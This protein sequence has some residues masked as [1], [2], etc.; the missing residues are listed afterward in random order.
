MHI[1][2]HSLASFVHLISLNETTLKWIVFLEFIVS[3]GLIIA[4]DG[5]DSEVLWTSIEYDSSFLGNRR[6]HEYCSEVNCIVLR[7]KW[8]L[9]LEII[10][11]ILRGIS[12]L[13]DELSHMYVSFVSTF[14]QI[15][16]LVLSLILSLSLNHIIVFWIFNFILFRLIVLCETSCFFLSELFITMSSLD[17][18]ELGVVHFIT[19]NKE[20][21]VNSNW[22]I[23]HKINI[24]H[25]L[26]LNVF[27]IVNVFLLQFDS[28][29]TIRNSVESGCHQVVALWVA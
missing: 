13:T 19:I 18:S 8:N 6:S 14:V 12:Y 29:N 1:V 26:Q 5:C 7:V 22:W 21:I 24:S 4:K 25:V 2:S 27:E 16:S 23:N 11:V 10:S 9:K 3:S 17:L 28:Y 15:L 20:V